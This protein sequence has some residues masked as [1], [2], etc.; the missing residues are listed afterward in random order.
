VERLVRTSVGAVRLGG[1]RVGTLRE[2]TA[3]ELAGLYQE[4][5]G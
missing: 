5:D 3:D 1:Q 2:L 4:L